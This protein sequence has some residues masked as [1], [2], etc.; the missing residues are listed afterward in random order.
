MR[1]H[2]HFKSHNTPST[3]VHSLVM[4]LSRLIVV[5][6]IATPIT[7]SAPSVPITYVPVYINHTAAAR[8]EPLC[9]HNANHLIAYVIN[10]LVV[11][12]LQTL[13]LTARYVS[14]YR[15][16]DVFVNLDDEHSSAVQASSAW[17]YLQGEYC[18]IVSRSLRLSIHAS[19]Q[20]QSP[21]ADGLYTY[22]PI[23]IT[24]VYHM[25]VMRFRQRRTVFDAITGGPM[26]AIQ[27][28]SGSS[29]PNL[30]QYPHDK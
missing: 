4:L 12:N 25:L 10:Q 9:R 17:P 18:F 22:L 28:H 15:D 29:M 11:S 19:V 13:R 6:V 20:R 21:A 3:T 7:Q 2:T 27:M 23:V 30:G 14:D 5:L 8:I 1:P 16:A 26:Y 24:S